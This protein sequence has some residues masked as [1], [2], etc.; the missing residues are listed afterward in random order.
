MVKAVSPATKK[1]QKLRRKAINGGELD[2][3]RKKRPRVRKAAVVG[4][5]GA[6]KPRK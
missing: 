3:E 5:P 2:D 4:R 1:V 6:P